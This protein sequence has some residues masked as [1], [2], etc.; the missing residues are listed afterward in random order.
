MG[1]PVVKG[2]QNLPTLDGIGLTD[3][4]NIGGELPSPPRPPGSGITVYRFTF[5]YNPEQSRFKWKQ[6]I[7]ALKKTNLYSKKCENQ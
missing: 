6:K 5:M 3:L 7:S 4:P 2:G 1:V